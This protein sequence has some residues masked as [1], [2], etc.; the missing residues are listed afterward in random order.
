MSSAMQGKVAIKFLLNNSLTGSLIGTGGHAIKE[1]IE[2]SEARV[3]VSGPQELYPGTTE[4]VVLIMGTETNVSAAQSLVWL[5]LA[6]NAKAAE[7]GNTRGVSWSPRQATES[8]EEFDHVH[9]DGKITVPAAAGGLIL[10]RGGA[11]IKA[12]AEDS[13]ARL[14]MTGKEEAIF[15]QE[16]IITISG[17]VQACAKATSQIISKL[18][19]DEEAAQ[20][21]NRG[22]TYGSPAH[23]MTGT[24][25]GSP[26]QDPRGQR[27]GRG[28]GALG[29]GGRGGNMFHD[30]ATDA[31]QAASTTISLQVPDAIIGNI[32]GKQGSTMRE[33]M[34]LSGA[35]VVVSP[36]G[37]YVDG[38]TN[39]IVTITGTPSSAQAAHMFVSQKL[40][41]PFP[42]RRTSK[43]SGNGGR[44]G[45]GGNEGANNEA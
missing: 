32:L 19:E 3:N 42:P 13:G 39:R 28:G 41:S 8:M 43:G 37:D 45:R 22:T 9:V 17:T 34:S 18:A 35:K 36:R 6:Q 33:I 23:G 10:G 1:L 21:V 27:Q 30:P 38:T 24:M 5:M 14:Q 44:G 7:E 26:S 12:I 29:S 16:R 4:R 15:T 31:I 40:Q 20:F 11:T 25:Y 2:V